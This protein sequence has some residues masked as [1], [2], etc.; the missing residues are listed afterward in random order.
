MYIQDRLFK[1]DTYRRRLES[2]LTGSRPKETECA[3]L[4]T[5]LRLVR[6]KHIKG[7]RAIFKQS[8]FLPS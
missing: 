1:Q 8:Y 7:N 6:I 4:V 5:L 2:Y 3:F